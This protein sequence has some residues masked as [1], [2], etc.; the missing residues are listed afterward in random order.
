MKLQI[1][2]SASMF[3]KNNSASYLIDDHILI[4]MP[5]GNCTNLNRLGLKIE[6]IDNVLITHFHGDHF[7]DMPIYFIKKS[8]EDELV[9]NIYCTKPGKRKIETL[10]KLAFPNS[11]KR[12]F[13]RIEKNY[14]YTS[15][16]TI[17]SYEVSRIKVDHGEF[18]SSYG[19]IFKSDNLT[20][21][22]TGD[23]T[24][25]DNVDYMASVCDYLV[26]DCT[27]IYGNESHMGIDDIK[28][29]AAKYPEHKFVTSHMAHETAKEAKKL[30]I[31]NII[32]PND[33]DIIIPDDKNINK[34]N[35]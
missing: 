12:H 15:N 27:F 30:K 29:L 6:E 13:S 34:R 22:F 26:C 20:L 14:I 7:L 4:D 8:K 18:K 2:G 1:I 23:T 9:V 16:F 5:N 21:G 19:Y 35:L 32:V 31:K 17:G 11:V 3:Q 24:Y 28:K 33:G 10:Y 25:C